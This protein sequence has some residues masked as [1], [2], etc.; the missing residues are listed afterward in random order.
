MYDQH[1]VDIAHRRRPTTISSTK[2]GQAK[3]SR[4]CG[5]GHSTPK[6]LLRNRRLR[7]PVAR[8][9]FAEEHENHL[10]QVPAGDHQR[11]VA[12]ERP[13]VTAALAMGG[14]QAQAEELLADGAAAEA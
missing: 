13:G 14:E 1:R 4:S 7:D 6:L 2:P 3:T 8:A 9:R 10:E 12:D 5:C 11:H